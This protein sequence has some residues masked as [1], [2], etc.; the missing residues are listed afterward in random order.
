MRLYEGAGTHT[1]NPAGNTDYT[2]IWEQDIHSLW[3]F[4]QSDNVVLSMGITQNLTDLRV[5]PALEQFYVI[6]FDFGN[7]QQIKKE[8]IMTG[9]LI[10]KWMTK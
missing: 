9:Y 1:E 6:T 4:T 10:W 2:V 8:K 3:K 7:S 5:D